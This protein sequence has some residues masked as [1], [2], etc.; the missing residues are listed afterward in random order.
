M[1]QYNFK[2]KVDGVCGDVDA[3]IIYD[4]FFDLMKR[5]KPDKPV[6]PDTQKPSTPSHTTKIYG[7]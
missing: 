7:C 5:K 1:W 2:A 6:L 3:N 4:S